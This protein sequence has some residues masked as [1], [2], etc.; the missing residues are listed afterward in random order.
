[1]LINYNALYSRIL[2]ISEGKE[3]CIFREELDKVSRKTNPEV[4]NLMADFTL[5]L[6][7]TGYA[8]EDI[9]YIRN[10]IFIDDIA[11]CK[12]VGASRISATVEMCEIPTDNPFV[13]EEA[14]K[15]MGRM[16]RIGRKTVED[17]LEAFIDFL[18]VK[19]ISDFTFSE[20][21]RIE[22]YMAACRMAVPYFAALLKERQ[23]AIMKKV[24]L[25]CGGDT[26]D[27]AF[28]NHFAIAIY[29]EKTGDGHTLDEIIRESR[30]KVAGI[31]EYSLATDEER[32]RYPT[33]SCYLVG[34]ESKIGETRKTIW[35]PEDLSV[36][37][38]GDAI[39]TFLGNNEEMI[40]DTSL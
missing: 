3:D 39:R 37:Q 25:E 15:I 10:T 12:V 34:P 24:G 13:Q 21:V 6:L 27:R 4:A 20:F 26:S 28:T 18:K 36:Y 7:K 1:M 35:Y 2:K 33:Y 11:V 17:L 16:N 30:G 9:D 8:K 40:Q 5:Y 31:K 23:Y 29:D 19:K 38:I 22:G 14:K 32:Y